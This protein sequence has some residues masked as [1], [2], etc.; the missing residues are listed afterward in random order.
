M[1]HELCSWPALYLAENAP[2]GVL[3]QAVFA[4]TGV[5]GGYVWA[6][7]KM[8]PPSVLVHVPWMF[9]VGHAPSLHLPTMRQTFFNP[10]LEPLP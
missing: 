8:P 1:G 9:A 4:L 2:P 5:P 3:S 10:S 6:L 7:F